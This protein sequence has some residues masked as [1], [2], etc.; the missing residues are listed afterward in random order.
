MS[1]NIK[2]S[3]VTKLKK[4]KFLPIQNALIPPDE[5]TFPDA[6]M[7]VLDY[8]KLCISR[9][10]YQEVDFELRLWASTILDLL[11]LKDKAKFEKIT[12]DYL[13]RIKLILPVN[14][15]DLIKPKFDELFE[16]FARSI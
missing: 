16:L 8:V 1:R 12:E 4:G 13:F 10:R 7:N 5:K 11:H 3:S 6:F 15:F 2:S 14:K 9:T